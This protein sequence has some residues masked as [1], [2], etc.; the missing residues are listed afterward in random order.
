M[1]NTDPFPAGHGN[2]AT[3][4]LNVCNGCL[5]DIVAIRLEVDSLALSS[6]SLC[7]AHPFD[8]V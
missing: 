8:N 5:A 4:N 3:L 7:S 1:P 2:K 6:V